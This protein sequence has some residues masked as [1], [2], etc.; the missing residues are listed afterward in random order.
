MTELLAELQAMRTLSDR[1]TDEIIRLRRH[2]D[3]AEQRL[4]APIWKGS[5]RDD[6]EEGGD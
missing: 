6:D 2:I 1:I 4:R 5:V 3:R